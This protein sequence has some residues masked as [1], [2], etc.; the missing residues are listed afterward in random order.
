MTLS[1]YV[2]NKL[3][4]MPQYSFTVP[5]I[6]PWALGTGTGTFCSPLLDTCVCPC[7]LSE[8]EPIVEH[9]WKYDIN[10]NSCRQCIRI[11]L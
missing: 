5:G 9:E 11:I 3:A 2:W 1:L 7:F 6:S 10:L 8:K 4:K